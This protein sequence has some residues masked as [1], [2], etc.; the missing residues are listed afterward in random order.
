[1]VIM[2]RQPE[3][4]TCPGALR[5]ALAQMG[6]RASAQALFEQ[7]K[8]QGHWTDGAIWQTITSHTINFP[9][10]Y[11]MYSMV[12]PAQRFLFLREDGNYELYNRDW[13]GRFEVGKRVV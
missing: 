1:M 8:K 9:P 11:H 3:P 12:T 6:N 7:V 13:H 2:G 4:E 10:S 5:T